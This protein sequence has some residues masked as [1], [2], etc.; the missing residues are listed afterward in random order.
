MS[1]RNLVDGDLAFINHT[2]V[3]QS[4]NIQVHLFVGSQI[5][6]LVG[7]S[8]L[9]RTQTEALLRPGGCGLNLG[10]VN[11]SLWWQGYSGLALMQ[12]VNKLKYL[13]RFGPQ[14]SAILLHCGGS[15]LGHTSIRKLRLQTKKV[16][17][18]IKTNFPNA[19]IIWSCVLPRIAWKYSHNRP[20]MEEAR[21]CLN[22]FASALNKSEGG[23][24]SYPDIKPQPTFLHSD[25]VHLSKLG[26]SIL[27][28]TLQGGLEAILCYNVVYFP[29]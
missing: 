24:I 21:R 18:F 12:V 13:S 16:T 4:C 7:S 20:K 10:R 15:D 28:N 9:K 3:Y 14:P 11:I 6:W 27:L 29:Q 8:I 17:K 19:R 23:V 2:S 26:N 25:G 1:F 22:P 5:V